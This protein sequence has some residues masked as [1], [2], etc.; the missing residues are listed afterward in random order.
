MALRKK[1]N[2]SVKDSTEALRKGIRDLCKRQGY[3]P[4]EEMIALAQDEDT[5]IDLKVRIHKE[6]AEYTVP[7]LRS[8]DIN[9]NVTTGL[10]V[11][12]VKFSD[13]V[14][15]NGVKELEDAEIIDERTN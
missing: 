14:L 10:T 11:N 3:D 8:I 13:K 6:I 2:M 1:P 9:A 12:V 7:K 15:M 5:P 4:I